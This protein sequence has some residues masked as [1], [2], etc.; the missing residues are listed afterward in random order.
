MVLGSLLLHPV[1]YLRV[2]TSR[3]R[4]RRDALGNPALWWGFLVPLPFTLVQIVRGS[5]WQDA[6]SSAAT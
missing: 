5:A 2:H 3:G 6:P 4:K 1:V